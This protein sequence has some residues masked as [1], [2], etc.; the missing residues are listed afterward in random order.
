[1]LFTLA[2]LWVLPV[3]VIGRGE[4][5]TGGLEYGGVYRRFTGFYAP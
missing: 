2:G 5:G 3:T 4:D 1:M